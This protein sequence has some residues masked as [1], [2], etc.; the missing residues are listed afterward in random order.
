MLSLPVGV[1]EMV[2]AVWLLGKG[3][4]PKAK[5][6]PP[7]RRQPPGSLEELAVTIEPAGTIVTQARTWLAGSSRTARPAWSACITCWVRRQDAGHR[8]ARH[9]MGP[10]SQRKASAVRMAAP[11]VQPSTTSNP[12]AGIGQAWVPGWKHASI[13][14]ATG[15]TGK[16]EAKS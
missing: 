6:P 1:Q 16:A 3:F 5:V 8:R 14:R 2:L 4:S 11:A 12:E 13:A 7:R 9:L 15:A 10:G